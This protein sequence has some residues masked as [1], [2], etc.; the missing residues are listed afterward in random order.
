[1]HGAGKMP[2]GSSACLPWMRATALRPYEEPKIGHE[3]IK[4]FWLDDAGEVFSAVAEPFAVEGKQAVVRIE[5][6]Y[7]EPVQQEYRDLGCFSS[8]RTAGC[9]TS[10][11]ARIGRPSCTQ[12]ARNECQTRRTVSGS[13]PS[14]YWSMTCRK[15]S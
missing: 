5:V 10:R 1:M 15:T 3:G 7:G 9:V 4:A 13:G 11:N 2:K 6:R 12:L 14:K 8:P